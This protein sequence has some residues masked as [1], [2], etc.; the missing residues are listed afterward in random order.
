MAADASGQE[1]TATGQQAS[2]SGTSAGSSSI[3]LGIARFAVSGDDEKKASQSIAEVIPRLML[4]RLASLP[5][6]AAPPEE[7]KESASLTE[8]RALFSA[9]SDLATKLDARSVAFFDPA[10]APEARKSA[11][12]K[13]DK[14]VAES[15]KKLD[16]AASPAPAPAPGPGAARPPAPATPVLLWAG[17][18]KGDLVDSK[19]GAA[20]AAKSSGAGLLVTGAI[21]LRSGYA[22]VTITGYDRSLD[23]NTFEWKDACSVEDPA[24]LAEEAAVR[25]ERWVAGRDFARLELRV[26]PAS[27]RVSVDGR[28]CDRDRAVYVFKPGESLI[29]AEAIGF[30]P[31]RGAVALAPGDRRTLDIALSPLSLGSALVVVDPPGAT[32]RV[33]SVPVGEAPMSVALDGSRAIVA[34]SAEGRESAS[35]VLPASGDSTVELTLP[36]ADELGPAGRVEDARNDFFGALGWLVGSIPVTALSVGAYNM[37]T[38]AEAR[39]PY[40]STSDARIA[41]GTALAVASAGTA[42]AAVNMIIHLVKYLRATR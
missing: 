9:G 26:S 28:E 36:V 30:L 19:A 33:D 31:Y 29:E 6:R 25:I 42:V 27:A 40:Q 1:A 13:A 18:A 35:V 21:E 5:P 23:R 10:T 41:S 8:L 7:A 14:A 39:S 38:E 16:A 17:H 20:A 32:V 22:T 37:Y 15:K 11:L 34:A 4:D 3:S 24:P 12:D 2:A